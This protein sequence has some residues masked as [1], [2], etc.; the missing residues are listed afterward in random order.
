MFLAA[1]TSALQVYP[2]AVHANRAWLSREFAS[3]YPHTEH[4]WLVKCGL[5][6]TFPG[7]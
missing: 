4:R 2:Q 7:R 1:F 6:L 5:I 3:T